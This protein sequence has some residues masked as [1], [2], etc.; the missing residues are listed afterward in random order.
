MATPGYDPYA[1]HSLY[2]GSGGLGSFGH[3]VLLAEYEDVLSADRSL[4]L[5]RKIIIIVRDT[6]TH[7]AKGVCPS[8]RL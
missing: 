4:L 2:C 6:L 1:E 8:P 5:V 7:P 3:V